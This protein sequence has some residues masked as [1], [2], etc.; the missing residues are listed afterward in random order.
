MLP[1]ARKQTLKS[2]GEEAKTPTED[3]L[4]EIALGSE[5]GGNTQRD[6]N[7]MENMSQISGSAFSSAGQSIL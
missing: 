6:F 2:L 4:T 7:R 1:V 3:Q 5:I